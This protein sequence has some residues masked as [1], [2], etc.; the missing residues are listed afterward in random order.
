MEHV[1][2]NMS[3]REIIRNR[4]NILLYNFRHF[5][6][7]NYDQKGM[8]TPSTPVFVDNFTFNGNSLWNILGF[9]CHMKYHDDVGCDNAT[10]LFSGFFQGLKNGAGLLENIF[11]RRQ[12]RFC[13]SFLLNAL[14]A[15]QKCALDKSATKVTHPHRGSRKFI[16]EPLRETLVVC[17]LLW[18]HYT[19][20][21]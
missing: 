12:P 20:V 6:R 4:L 7:L 2:L 18:H 17:F 3:L 5:K 15:L 19:R 11:R 8:E 21:E 10:A 16:L 14:A 9:I 13:F 1:V